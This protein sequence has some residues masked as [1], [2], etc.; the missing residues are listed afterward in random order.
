MNSE[1]KH[2][3]ALILAAG[4]GNRMQ[5]DITKQMMNLDGESVVVRSVRAFEECADISS[6]VVVAK[7][8]EL[9]RIRDMLSGKSSK[10]FAV[11]AGGKCRQESALKG[12]AAIPSDAQFVAVHD[13]ARCLVLPEMISKVVVSALKYGAATAGHPVYD[14]VKLVGK[15]GEI[16]GTLNRDELFVASTPQI[17]EKGIYERALRASSDRLEHYTDDNMMVEAIGESIATVNVGK[18]NLKITTQEDLLL[19]RLILER[20]K[21]LNIE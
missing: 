12:F 9:S 4:S 14:T 20:R 18:E 17:F 2:I 7:D 15:N 19:A 11:V 21:C 13:A 5:S 3:S 10:L 1:R 16:S 6:I 8:D